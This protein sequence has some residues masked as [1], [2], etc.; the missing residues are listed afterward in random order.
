MNDPLTHFRRIRLEKW[1]VVYKV[2]EVE[3]VIT[4]IKVG[5]KSGTG[6]DFYEDLE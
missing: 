2:D 3:K 6:T 4:I 5:E 1:R